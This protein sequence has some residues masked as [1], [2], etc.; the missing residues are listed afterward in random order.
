M[1][2]ERRLLDD[3]FLT[4]KERIT[5]HEALRLMRAR[6][7]PVVARERVALHTAAGRICAEEITAPRPIPADDNAAVDGYAFRHADY[8]AQ[9][10]VFQIGARIAAGHPSPTALATGEAAQ[11]FTGAIMPP[12]TD[13][14]AMQ[15]DCRLSPD[16]RRVD[17]PKG[18]KPGANR[19]KAGEDQPEG[20]LIAT[21]GLTLRPQELAAIA[22]SG[23][24]HLQVYEPLTV[25]LFSS[26]DEIKRPGAPFAP[27]MVYDSN[28]ALLN[29]LLAS[30]GIEARDLGILND[31]VH[32]VTS[33]LSAAA[34][35][36]DV[37]LT[38]GGA[39]R[40]EE[41]H[42][43]AALDCLGK[44]HLWQL[45]IKPGRPMMFGQIG[46]TVVLSLPGNP[47]AVFVCF[48]LFV[49]P[50]LQLL[51]GG[52]FK[53][54]TRFPLPAAFSIDRK[55]PDRREFLRG[56]LQ[57]DGEGGLSVAKFPRDGSGLITGLTAS[58][59]L[60][61]LAEPVTSVDR[62]DLVNFIPYS[63]FGLPPRS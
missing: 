31:S 34:N 8:V 61:E 35:D 2:E 39:S 5:Y 25:G 41:D 15:E 16:G 51:S 63:E 22:S 27:G 62:G 53:A 52:R 7:G 24:G 50:C 54:P 49:I 44:R 3:C 26:G 10:G 58:D 1:S 48:V 32:D 28:H 37:I 46:D 59:G 55:K 14:V 19:R 18:L 21:P 29:G 42:L 45:A 9:D 38:T 60:I 36:H 56:V 20:A 43:V 4:D 33:R 13:S 17:I 57:Q 12:G 40:G 23:A 30:Q 47:V 6:L 11:I